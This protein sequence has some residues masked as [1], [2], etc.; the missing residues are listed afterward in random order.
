M[1]RAP[2][3]S[4]AHRAAARPASL[5]E[6]A[7]LT[8][9]R[10]VI[11]CELPPGAEVGEQDLA[12]R[13]KMSKTPVREALGR[14]I[15]EGLVEAFPRRGYRVTPVTVK[16]VN[17]LFT[18]RSALEALAVELAVERMTEADLVQ[19]EKLAGI[20]YVPGEEPTVEAFVTANNHFHRAIAV[21][22]GVPRLVTLLSQQLE[23][24]T[25]LFHLGAN[26]RDVNPET[27]TDHK[28]ILE[29]LRAR[30]AASARKAV[31]EHAEHTR[32]GLL[33]ALISDTRS[34]LHL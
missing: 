15:Q 10:Q 26:A 29:A 34:T 2:K 31:Q 18:V 33:F 12:A 3:A 13:L 24:S 22:S 8:L 6:Q 19:L 25:R 5:T 16:D 1:T 20:A 17:D 30:D 32:K 28:R 7:Y 4:A 23:E 21:A 27:S 9:R 14:L 11:T